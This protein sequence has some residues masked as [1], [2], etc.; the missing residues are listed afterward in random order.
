M[1][2]R[3]VRRPSGLWTPEGIYTPTRFLQGIQ[4]R[5]LGVFRTKAGVSTE[6]GAGTGVKA[7]TGGVTLVG[8]TGLGGNPVAIEQ[9]RL[10]GINGTYAS[11]YNVAV[12]TGYAVKGY[13]KLSEGETE[14][15][16]LCIYTAADNTLRKVSSVKAGGVTGWNEFTFDGT[17]QLN[18][19]TAYHLQV[20]GDAGYIHVDT[21]DGP[22]PDDTYMVSSYTSPATT[23]SPGDF[24]YVTACIYIT[25]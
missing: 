9:N 14:N 10:Y 20:I 18:S 22:D 5:R 19:A 2:E 15:M 12:A 16:K 7:A 25:N 8:Y 1:N 13:V 3:C 4:S 23:Y 6:V 24:L 17:Y 11:A 21:Y